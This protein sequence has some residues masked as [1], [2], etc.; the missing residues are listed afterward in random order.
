MPAAIQWSFEVGSARLGEFWKGCVLY[1]WNLWCFTFPL[2]CGGNLYDLLGQAS[3]FCACSNFV[4]VHIICCL[5]GKS[6]VLQMIAGKL[7]PTSG[8]VF[9]PPHLQ[10]LQALFSNRNKPWSRK[11]WGR[12]PG[13]SPTLLGG[14]HTQL[15]SRKPQAESHFWS[16]W[17]W[18]VLGI[19]ESIWW[20]IAQIP[21]TVVNPAKSLEE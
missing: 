16:F 13:V 14:G 6:T 2:S 18:F 1:L 11:T 19:L 3:P 9:I 21:W 17:W 20:N 10:V 15:P 7:K 4:T 8:H 5:Q 12:N